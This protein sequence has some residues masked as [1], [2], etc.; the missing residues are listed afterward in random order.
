MLRV[1]TVSGDEAVC[2]G[3]G[4]GDSQ[5][6]T[7]VRL[8]LTEEEDLGDNRKSVQARSPPG[9]DLSIVSSGT[10]LAGKSG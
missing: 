3:L 9:L 4:L 7:S 1:L 5:K 6:P 8:W 10:L 2:V